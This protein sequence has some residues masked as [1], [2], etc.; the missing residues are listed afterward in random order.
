MKLSQKDGFFDVT[1]CP[2]GILLGTF[3]AV[4]DWFGVGIPDITDIPKCL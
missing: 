1:P 2:S 3:G 4:C